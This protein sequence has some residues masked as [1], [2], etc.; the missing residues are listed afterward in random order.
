MWKKK[1]RRSISEEERGDEEEEKVLLVQV[2][3]RRGKRLFLIAGEGRDR[4]WRSL[5]V[6]EMV[7]KE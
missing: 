2:G 7:T 4:I 3:D 6:W 5:K 1:E